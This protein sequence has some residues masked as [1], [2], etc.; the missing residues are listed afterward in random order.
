M[1]VVYALQPIEKS[2][3]LA[4]PTPRNETVPT[5]RPEALAALKRM[6]FDG[7]VYVPESHDWAKHDGYDDQIDWEWAGLDTARVIVF[8]VPRDLELDDKGE[9]KMPAFT[10]NVEFGLTAMGGK[11]MLGAPPDAP[12]T[13]YLK[14]LAVRV[15][16]PFFNDLES[17]LAAAV[18]K[19]NADH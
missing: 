16:M 17:L 3:F 9:M 11:C 10:T 2:I 18:A 12:K 13:K 5:W 19:L 14:K 15:G 7:T 4:G 1:K 8:W 6:G